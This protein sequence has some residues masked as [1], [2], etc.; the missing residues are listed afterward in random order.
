MVRIAHYAAAIASAALVALGGPAWAKSEPDHLRGRIASVDASSIELSTERGNQRISLA[1]NTAVF[2]LRPARFTDLTFGTYVGSVA[3]RLDEYSPIVRD[4]MSWLHR[5]FEL[6]IIDEALRGIAV[7]AQAWDKPPGT[8]MSHGWVDDIEDR[9][10]S[11]KYGPTEQE[12][13]DVD[14]RRAQIMRMSL[15]SR[16]MLRPGEQV[17]VGANRAA[18]GYVAAF[19][20]LGTN[21]IVPPL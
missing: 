16:D 11:I 12:E 10:L 14:T 13:T 3:V 20:F 19:V 15:G 21:G 6:R 4:S 9:V 18:G 5:G 2:V 17:F 8:L 7:G 1:P